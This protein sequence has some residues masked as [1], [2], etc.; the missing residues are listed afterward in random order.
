MHQLLPHPAPSTHSPP[1]RQAARWGVAFGTIGFFLL[2]EARHPSAAMAPRA[3]FR[4]LSPPLALAMLPHPAVSPN[5]SPLPP[6][7]ARVSTAQDLPQLILQTQYGNW[8]GW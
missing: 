5:P 7:C 2:Y 6:P 3:L 4:A 8:P 1:L